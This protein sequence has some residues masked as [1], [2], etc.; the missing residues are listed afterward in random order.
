MNFSKILTRLLGSLMLGL[1]T[2]SA[3][4]EPSGLPQVL[5]FSKT[6]GFRHDSIAA[7]I[8]AIRDLGAKHPF[9]VEATED[10]GAFTAANLSRFKAVVFLSVTGDVLNP[11][12][13]RAF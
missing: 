10:A 7:G 11:D 4:T 6:S 5:V 2:A 3:A 13:E 1:A 8:T 12:Q 9:Q